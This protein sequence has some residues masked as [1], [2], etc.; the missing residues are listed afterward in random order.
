MNILAIPGI[1][2]L[3]A[4]TLAAAA[5]GSFLFGAAVSSMTM[6]SIG[7]NWR[8][9]DVGA[10]AMAICMPIFVLLGLAWIAVRARILRRQANLQG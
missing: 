3:L 2:P 8:S 9:I 4:K 10:I 5:L 1:W 6:F 7:I